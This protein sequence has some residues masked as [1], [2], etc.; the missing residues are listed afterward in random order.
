MERSTVPETTKS[1]QLRVV[2]G[3]RCLAFGCCN[4]SVNSSFSMHAMPGNMPVGTEQFSP[5][6]KEWI[7]FIG[8]KRK[9]DC[10]DARNY[11]NIIVCSGH[12]KQEDFDSTQFE[13]FRRGHRKRPPRLL[14]GAVPSLYD[15]AQPFPPACFI[16]PALA[17]SPEDSTSN[18]ECHYDS[19]GADE[20][21]FADLTDC[22]DSATYDV[23]L[24]EPEE[25]E[26]SGQNNLKFVD[27]ST[28]TPMQLSTTSSTQYN[29]ECCDAAVQVPEPDAAP[30]SPECVN[31]L[32][33][34]PHHH[35][36]QVHLDKTSVLQEDVT[37]IK[38]EE[39]K[40]VPCDLGWV[41]DF[42]SPIQPQSFQVTDSLPPYA[43]HRQ[44]SHTGPSTS[45]HNDR[46]TSQRSPEDS[47]TSQE[48][49]HDKHDADEPDF[50]DSVD[51]MDSGI[52]TC[53]AEHEEPEPHEVTKALPESE[54]NGN[55][56]QKMIVK[57]KEEPDWGDYSDT[58][59][60]MTFQVKR[61]AATLA[62]P[63]AAA[64]LTPD[65][66]KSCGESESS[67]MVI[68]REHSQSE[69]VL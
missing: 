65:N 60:E 61:E 15:A 69:D 58:A 5:L 21:D 46:S 24:E 64:A 68:K 44:T 56:D 14:P 28:Q 43:S 8:R 38:S 59:A 54:N 17:S 39:E 66:A 31:D 37:R 47:T 53:D 34:A 26:E 48:Y 2:G 18:Q 49:Q 50:L 29:V 3:K 32:N 6:Q 57:I 16:P 20:S 1:E 12:F 55:V 67:A 45:T 41:I 30:S 9:F 33:E 40:S 63:E 19:L 62:E 42:P 51:C 10:K 4:S 25:Y 11:S 27:S 13:M 35:P 52:C 7:T 36:A 23:K 22:M